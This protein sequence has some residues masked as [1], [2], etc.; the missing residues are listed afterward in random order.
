MSKEPLDLYLA[1]L[2]A[3]GIDGKS[4]VTRYN[5]DTLAKTSSVVSHIAQVLCKGGRST[6]TGFV[7]LEF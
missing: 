3:L 7:Q 2:E 1:K 5:P 4:Q 6:I